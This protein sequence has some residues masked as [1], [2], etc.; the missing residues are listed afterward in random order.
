MG[1]AR[2]R[3]LTLWAFDEKWF[4]WGRRYW[5]E[6]GARRAAKYLA[7][8]G[9]GLP[10]VLAVRLVG[11]QIVAVGHAHVSEEEP[12][13]GVWTFGRRSEGTAG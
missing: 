4:E 1:R 10:P 3:V 12:C 13:R 7:E 6:R 8:H 9:C 2:W 5:T 11:Y